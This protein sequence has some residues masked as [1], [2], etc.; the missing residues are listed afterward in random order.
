M[1]FYIFSSPV[2]IKYYCYVAVVFSLYRNFNNSDTSKK[3]VG[4]TPNTTNLVGFEYGASIANS[5]FG[6][7]DARPV[8]IGAK[9]EFVRGWVFPRLSHQIESLSNGVKKTG[10]ERSERP[11]ETEA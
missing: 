5:N 8:K 6:F 9:R 3:G 2:L 10:S 7:I 4:E 11:P 1:N